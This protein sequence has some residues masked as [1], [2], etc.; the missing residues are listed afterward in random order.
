MIKKVKKEEKIYAEDDGGNLTLSTVT[1]YNPA[2]QLIWEQHLFPSGQV[3]M[4]S[5]F[6]YTDGLLS[7][8]KTWNEYGSW[9]EIKYL[10]DDR[11]ELVYRTTEHADGTIETYK[12]TF[13]KNSELVEIYD[14]EDNLD[15]REEAICD[16]MGRAIE[17]IFYEDGESVKV[18]QYEYNAEGQMVKKMTRSQDG[19][20]E[21]LTII[22]TYQY[23]QYGN[24]IEEIEQNINGVILYKIERAYQ[25]DL[26]L[27]EIENDFEG[28]EE[29]VLAK[30]TYDHHERLIQIR[31]ENKFGTLTYHETMDYNEDGT[32]MT[33]KTLE[34]APDEYSPPSK[35]KYRYE[36]AYF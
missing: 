23:D 18:C 13:S 26:I 25:E 10:Y 24:V 16:E 5:A 29:V 6:E 11:Q 17:R 22:N 27:R 33:S 15:K 1:K 8:E 35:K 12:R 7:R 14:A 36:I 4:E 31:I 20:G 32:L 19:F 30:Y 28:S 34:Q 2:G 21:E 9:T 3:Q